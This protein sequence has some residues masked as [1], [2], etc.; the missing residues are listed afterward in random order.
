MQG[1]IIAIAKAMAF[2]IPFYRNFPP[3][4]V[5]GERRFRASGRVEEPV[6]FQCCGHALR[7][8]LDP[9]LFASVFE[10]PALPRFRLAKQLGNSISLR[11]NSEFVCR[12]RSDYDRRVS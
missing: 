11:S 3:S 9:E 4:R 8:L 10:F 2:F 1:I 6:A 12:K 5:S 7:S